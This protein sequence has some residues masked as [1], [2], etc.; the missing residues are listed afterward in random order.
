M[1]LNNRLKQNLKTAKTKNGKI[2]EL[3]TLIEKVKKIL[4]IS[5]I[6]DNILNK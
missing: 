3:L 4:V 1:T 5:I 2:S 6:E